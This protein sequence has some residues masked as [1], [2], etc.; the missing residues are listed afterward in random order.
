MYY[1]KYIL[2]ST[3]AVGMVLFVKSFKMVKKNIY[4][5]FRNC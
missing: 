1:F 4:I 5:L 2:N 3:F